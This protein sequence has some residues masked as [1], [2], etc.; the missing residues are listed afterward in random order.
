MGSSHPPLKTALSLEWKK[1]E[2]YESGSLPC[3][4][5]EKTDSF[6]S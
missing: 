4:A 2:I 1:L 5:R 6:N 3:E